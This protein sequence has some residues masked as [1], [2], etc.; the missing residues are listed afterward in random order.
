MNSFRYATPAA[1]YFGKEC[2][3]KNIEKISSCGKKILILTSHFIEG[4]KNVALEDVTNALDKEGCTYKIIDNVGENPTVEQVAEVTAAARE[5]GPDSII[6]IGGGSVIDCSKA[7]SCYLPY[8]DA[9]PYDHFFGEWVSY[10]RTGNECSIPVFSV[11]T[12]AGTGADVTGGAV[13]TRQ[14]T[15]TKLT[16][17]QFLVSKASFLDPRYIEGSPY[18]LLDTG[19]MDTLAH[20]V[21]TYVNVNSNFMNRSIAEIG[22]KLFSQYKDAL[23]AKTLSGDDFDKMQIAASVIGMAFM[24]ASVFVRFTRR[25]L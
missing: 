19:A 17:A 16:T 22:F 8:P 4:H 7:V 10:G 25:P 24:T 13:L 1:I 21:E 20:G 3:S 15:D 12:T 9:D 23:A 2:V 11:P 18:Y 5:F 6:A 14:D